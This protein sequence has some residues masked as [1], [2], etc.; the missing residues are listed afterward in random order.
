MDE[1][2]INHF[3]KKYGHPHWPVKFRPGDARTTLFGI[4]KTYNRLRW[5]MAVDIAGPNFNTYVPFDLKK[6]TFMGNVGGGFGTLLFLQVQ[7]ADF[8]IRIA[9]FQGRDFDPLFADTIDRDVLTAAGNFIGKQRGFEGL[10]TGTHI[11]VEYVSTGKR[12]EV[13]DEIMERVCPEMI[14][15]E[16]SVN[17][18][19]NYAREIGYPVSSAEEDYIRESERRKLISMNPVYS[20][21]LDYM[22]GNTIEKTWYNSY[23]LFNKM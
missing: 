13:L 17:D 8:E 19:H 22:T 7:E 9:H 1:K 15:K 14:E 18:W 3:L 5:H 6:I 16:I 12:S 23:I 11:H 4:D 21:R 20:T 10:G 2:Q